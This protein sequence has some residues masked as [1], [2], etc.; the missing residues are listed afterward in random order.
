[1]LYA[2]LGLETKYLIISF[3][4]VIPL[5]HRTDNAVFR[6]FCR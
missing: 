3:I 6:G 5:V 1:M 4:R 2:T